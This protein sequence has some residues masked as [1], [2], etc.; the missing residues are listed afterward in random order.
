ME[1]P[2]CAC[3]AYSGGGGSFS[4]DCLNSLLF[5]GASPFLISIHEVKR[6]SDRERDA[7][8]GVKDAVAQHHPWKQLRTVV[9]LFYSKHHGEGILQF[10]WIQ[11]VNNG[12][13]QTMR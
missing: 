1:R 11:S 9:D 6:G 8:A 5:A 2:H 4:N 13:K 7:W 12:Q 10:A 3:N